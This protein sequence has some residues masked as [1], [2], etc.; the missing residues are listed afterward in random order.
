MTFAPKR[1]GFQRGDGDSFD[2][3][4]CLS[5]L[6]ADLGCSRAATHFDRHFG[7]FE[8]REL[9]QV[10]TLHPVAGQRTYTK[11]QTGHVS[12][13]VAHLREATRTGR[14]VT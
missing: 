5:E 13:P 2:H 11:G 1:D 3:R 12:H 10:E 4:H 9:V 7:I 6:W 14:G 8:C